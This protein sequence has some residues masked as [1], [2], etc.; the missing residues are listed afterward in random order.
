[1]RISESSYYMPY[2]PLKMNETG[3]EH[4]ASMPRS[5]IER[6]GSDKKEVS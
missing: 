6:H 2:A 5:R 1:M 4:M 3:S